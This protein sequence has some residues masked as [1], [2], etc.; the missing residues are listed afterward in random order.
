MLFS[1]T[2]TKLGLIQSCEMKLFG[3]N[4]YGQIS[5][6]TNRL[7]QFT[8]RLNRA[9]DRFVQLAIT[10]DG[11]W[12]YDDTNNADYP[13]ATTNIVSGQRDY[14]LDVTVFEVES[15][16]IISNGGTT[17]TLIHPF[18]TTDSGMLS[19]TYIENNST[20]TGTPLAYDKTANSIVFNCIPDYNATAG[21]KIRF[22]R[23]ANYFVY[24]DTTKVPGLPALFHDYLALN[25]SLGYAKDR[26]MVNQINTLTPQ[27]QEQENAIIDFF[28]K[29]SRDESKFIKGVRHSSR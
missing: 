16:S 18:D 29:R 13:E 14:P 25:A 21:L 6:N 20:N 10:S 8:G 4:G 17:Y 15:V 19:R 5:G 9:Q 24:T 12:Q 26:T 1:D 22:K 28:S 3:D 27:V 23:G 7:Y 11:R 2:T